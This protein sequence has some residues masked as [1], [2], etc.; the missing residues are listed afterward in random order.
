MLV[1]FHTWCDKALIRAYRA[2][3]SRTRV[4]IVCS[5]ISIAHDRIAAPLSVCAYHN[6]CDCQRQQSIVICERAA[7]SVRDV[8]C[9]MYRGARPPRFLHASD[10]VL[11]QF[12]SWRATT[13][14]T[15]SAAR[16]PH[17]ALSHATTTTPTTR[18][19][20]RYTK[21]NR[22]HRQRCHHHCVHRH[23]SHDHN[24]HRHHHAYKWARYDHLNASTR[25]CT[26][27]HIWV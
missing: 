24:K 4:S 8:H 16:C 11:N 2:C 17:A 13:E 27:S 19:P 26:P 1:P 14:S 20:P 23:I 22:S 5:C 21:H 7:V 15:H 25:S 6:A 9:A 18:A 3:Y 12:P 10:V